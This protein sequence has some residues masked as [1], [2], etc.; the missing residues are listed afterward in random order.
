ME[1]M[2]MIGGLFIHIY[3]DKRK[4]QERKIVKVGDM[5]IKINIS[6]QKENQIKNQNQNQLIKHQ[7]QYGNSKINIKIKNQ[8]FQ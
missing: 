4:L 5:I 6:K 8:R 7:Y 3:G 1:V 2:I